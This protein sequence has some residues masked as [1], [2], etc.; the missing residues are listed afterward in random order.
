MVLHMRL[1]LWV[2]GLWLAGSCPTNITTRHN[3]LAFLTSKCNQRTN[4]GV[5]G[6]L[7]ELWLQV[8]YTIHIITTN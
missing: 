3:P 5:I 4:S 2:I 6:E 1:L 8:E 7:N